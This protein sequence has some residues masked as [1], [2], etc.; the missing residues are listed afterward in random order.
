M[1][2]PIHAFS[3]DYAS[4]LLLYP[5]GMILNFANLEKGK[6]SVDTGEA[7]GL[8]IGRDEILVTLGTALI[9]IYNKTQIQGCTTD[10]Q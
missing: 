8:G 7:I 2:L 1:N 9:S 4:S 5:E 10:S 6:F 3:C